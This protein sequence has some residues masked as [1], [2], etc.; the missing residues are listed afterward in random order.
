MKLVESNLDFVI[1]EMVH[2]RESEITGLW[3]IGGYIVH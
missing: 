1:E 3:Y 2:K